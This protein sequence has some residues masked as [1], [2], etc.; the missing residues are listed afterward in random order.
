MKYRV[1]IDYGMEGFKFASD[2][3]FDTVNLAV[4]FA[5]KN[6]FGNTFLIV[7]IVGWAAV[8]IPTS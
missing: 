1:L 8:E 3:E 4:Q 7:H 5:I 6:S 2:D